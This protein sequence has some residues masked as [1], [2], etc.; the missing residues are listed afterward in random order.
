MN[1]TPIGTRSLVRAGASAVI[2]ALVISITAL[3]AAAGTPPSISGFSP[4]SGPVGTSVAINGANFAG[5]SA[6]RSTGPATPF[7][8]NGTG[9]QITVNVPPARPTA[10]SR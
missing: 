10:R 4:S 3:P 7:L 5:A 2:V 1:R 6:V 8:V 9:T